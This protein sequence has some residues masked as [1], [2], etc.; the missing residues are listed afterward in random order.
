M[1]ICSLLLNLL[2]RNVKAILDNIYKDRPEQVSHQPR[3]GVTRA[4]LTRV[5]YANAG[6]DVNAQTTLGKA[7]ALHRAAYMGH[8]HVVHFLYVS[9][10][11]TFT[12]QA[13]CWWL[14]RCL[15]VAR[16]QLSQELEL[17]SSMPAR[18]PAQHTIAR[19]LGSYGSTE[20]MFLVP[21][22][23]CHT[24]PVEHKTRGKWLD[25]H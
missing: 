15:S 7:T 5:H 16:I 13:V 14:C 18:C 23:P 12:W 22:D 24:N 1:S 25:Q 19:R 6:A 21:G 3:A 2:H 8:L 9:F 10:F 4:R 11:S 20:Q 17:A